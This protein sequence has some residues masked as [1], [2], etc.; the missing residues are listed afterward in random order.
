MISKNIHSSGGL[1]LEAI[2]NAIYSMVASGV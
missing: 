2:E 1:S